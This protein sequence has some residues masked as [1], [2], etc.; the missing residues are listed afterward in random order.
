MRKGFR[1]PTFGAQGDTPHKTE[2]TTAPLAPALRM[3]R[4]AMVGLV[5]AVTLVPAEG[6]LSS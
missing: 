2:D 3:A 6:S 1:G 4:K 5:V